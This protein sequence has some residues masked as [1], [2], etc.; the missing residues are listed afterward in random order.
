MKVKKIIASYALPAL[1][2]ANLA[3]SGCTKQ[4]P[5]LEN[6]LLV[7]PAM[8]EQI[9][10]VKQTYAQSTHTLP[11]KSYLSLL[12]SALKQ[13]HT[14]DSLLI[15]A[16]EKGKLPLTTS[17]EMVDKYKQLKKMTAT[18]NEYLTHH[19]QE[20]IALSK[21]QKKFYNL[22]RRNLYGFDY[23]K[24]EAEKFLEDEGQIIDVD[25]RR[26]FLETLTVCGA[27]I[28]LGTGLM[29]YKVNEWEDPNILE[30]GLLITGILGLIY[31]PYQP[32]GNN[33]H[34]HP[35]TY[36][37]THSRNKHLQDS[38]YRFQDSTKEDMKTP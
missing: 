7:E 5:A 3:L 12:Q 25:N 18:I 26:T 22:L 1:I 11:N 31:T 9:D 24:P 19:G 32:I 14:L 36:Q 8:Q 4:H 20:A 37:Q 10:H 6:S 35:Q 2:S 17:K 38:T 27:M 30:Y 33:H 28:A 16:S 15:D 13:S 29:A 23:G 34:I 21:K